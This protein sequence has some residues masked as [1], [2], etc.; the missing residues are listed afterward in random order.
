MGGVGT[1]GVEGRY[2]WLSVKYFTFL[3]SPF[4]FPGVGADHRAAEGGRG[5]GV[6][7]TGAC[8]GV[9]TGGRG[10]GPDLDPRVVFAQ[11]TRHAA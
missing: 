7:R 5:G 4:P 11:T 8:R 2:Y 3:S 9:G 10:P 6:P 1:E